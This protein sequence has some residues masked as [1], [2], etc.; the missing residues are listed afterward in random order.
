MFGKLSVSHV[1]PLARH[2]STYADGDVGVREVD[3]ESSNS[4]HS[5]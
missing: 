3:W 5:L 2:T 4:K 1:D